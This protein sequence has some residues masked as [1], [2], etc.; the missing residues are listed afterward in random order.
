MGPP[1]IPVAGMI[2]V[3]KTMCGYHISPWTRSVCQY[4]LLGILEEVIPI[5]HSKRA[6]INF[7]VLMIK[8]NISIWVRLEVPKH[9]EHLLEISPASK[10]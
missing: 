4:G 7:Q 5:V 6:L 1:G 9:M 8:S 10:I 3:H 2:S